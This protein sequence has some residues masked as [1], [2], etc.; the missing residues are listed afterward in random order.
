MPLPLY[1]RIP[2]RLLPSSLLSRR[3]YFSPPFLVRLFE[4]FFF[5]SLSLSLREDVLAFAEPHHR[6]EYQSVKLVSPRRAR[7]F[8]E[9]GG[10]EESVEKKNLSPSLSPSPLLLRIFSFPVIRSI[11]F[12]FL[13]P[14]VPFVP[15]REMNR[16]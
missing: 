1:L 11:F 15:P 8:S 14:I 10:K 12:F 4:F 6:G 7:N 3:R 16:R 9:D 2:P 13:L 5:F